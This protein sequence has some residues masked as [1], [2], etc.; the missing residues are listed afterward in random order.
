MV[1]PLTLYQKALA[2]FIQIQKERWVS[3]S[4][5]ESVLMGEF[6]I[7]FA[8]KRR[9]SPGLLSGEPGMGKTAFCPSPGYWSLQMVSNGGEESSVSYKGDR[10]NAKFRSPGMVTLDDHH[11]H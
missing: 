8:I 1:G 7:S 11:H 6:D 5:S 3:W 9:E 10:V 2:L 4:L